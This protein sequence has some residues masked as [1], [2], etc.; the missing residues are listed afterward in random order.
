MCKQ[1]AQVRLQE[2]VTKHKTV[3]AWLVVQT[4]N[5]V[6]SIGRDTMVLNVKMARR[7]QTSP[8]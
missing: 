7:Y 6:L 8:S 4:Y 1:L 3:L 2:Q 5:C